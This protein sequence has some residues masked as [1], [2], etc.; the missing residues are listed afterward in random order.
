MVYKNK[1]Q[2]FIEQNEITFAGTDSSLNGNCVILAGYA[3]Y[4]KMDIDTLIKRVKI[5]NKRAELELRRVYDYAKKAKYGE[6]WYTEKARE[7]YIF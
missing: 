2:I 4:L 5:I 7:L 1:I 6:F 3:C